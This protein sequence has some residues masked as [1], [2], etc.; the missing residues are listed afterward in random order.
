VAIPEPGVP[1]PPELPVKEQDVTVVAAFP[2]LLRVSVQVGVV[3]TRPQVA[4]V[5]LTRAEAVNDPNRPK[6]NPA[7]ATAAMSVIAMRMTVGRSIKN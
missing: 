1:V 4:D 2:V 3:L 5:T 6:T 7:M